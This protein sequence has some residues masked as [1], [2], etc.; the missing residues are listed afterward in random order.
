VEK[1]K[2]LHLKNVRIGVRSPVLGL[3]VR[4]SRINVISDV[5]QYDLAQSLYKYNNLDIKR[6]SMQADRRTAEILT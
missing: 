4:S 5:S 3:Y 1:R 6:F 2:N